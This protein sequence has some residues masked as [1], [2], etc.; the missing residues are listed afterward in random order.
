MSGG[1]IKTLWRIGLLIALAAL[2]G[3][4]AAHQET[5]YN[6]VQWLDIADTDGDGVINERDLCDQT[7]SMGLIDNRGCAQWQQVRGH[8]DFVVRF[9]FDRYEL[10]PDQL[11]VIEQIMAELERYPNARIVLVGDTSSEGT[12]DYNRRLGRQRADAI[13]ATLAE[14]GMA[15]DRVVEMVYDDPLLEGVLKER[16]RRTI[17]RVLHRE[18]TP[19]PRWTIYDTEN[20]RE[21][22]AR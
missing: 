22:V 13:L 9:D 17:V 21:D 5:G 19:V 16:Q 3:C 15:P 10:R 18:L 2:T 11:P 7:P 14:R 6:R 8:Q 1:P 4:Q 20:A 12:D